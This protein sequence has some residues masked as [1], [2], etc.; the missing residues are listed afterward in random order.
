LITESVVRKA[1]EG[2]MDPELHK[3]LIELGMIRKVRIRKDQ[4]DITLALTTM[5]CPLKEQIVG[6]VKQTVSALEGVRG[7]DVELTEMTDEEKSAAGLTALPD[8][9]YEATM[10]AKESELVRSTLGDHVFERF[11]TNKLMEWADYQAY[12]S[13]FEIK[14]YL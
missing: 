9:L 2:V 4:V 7:V 8:N 14:R 1:L 13:D 5:G 6:D 11:I 12:V 3:N 10:A